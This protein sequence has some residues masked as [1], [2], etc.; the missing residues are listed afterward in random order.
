MTLIFIL[1]LFEGLA[2]LLVMRAFFTTYFSKLELNCF[3]IFLTFCSIYTDI[4]T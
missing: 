1:F 4:H 2:K 3:V